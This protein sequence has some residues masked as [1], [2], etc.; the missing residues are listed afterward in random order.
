MRPDDSY[1]LSSDE[2]MERAATSLVLAMMRSA[3]TERISPMNW[4]PR[5]KSA[6]ETGA[7]MATTYRTMIS[8]MGRKLQIDATALSTSREISLLGAA[9]AEA[10]DETFERWRAM[11]ERDA[12]FLVAMAQAERDLQREALDQDLYRKWEPKI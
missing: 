7:A 1:D 11:C 3:S 10:G 9:L 12:L 6:L 8:S 4:W 2:G 5:A